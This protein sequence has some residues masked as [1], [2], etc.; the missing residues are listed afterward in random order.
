[1]GNSTLQANGTRQYTVHSAVEAGQ[2]QRLQWQRQRQRQRHDTT[3]TAAMASTGSM[4]ASAGATTSSASVKIEGK[5]A[6]APKPAAAKPAVTTLGGVERPKFV[7]RAQ[8]KKIIEEAN[9]L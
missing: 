5:S 3:T 1:V 4:N 6:G 8:P 9:Q 2:D 7:P